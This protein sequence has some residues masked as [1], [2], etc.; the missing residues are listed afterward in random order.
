MKLVVFLEV[1]ALS[2]ACAA[3][4]VLERRDRYLT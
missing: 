3:F 2:L 1:N 4:G